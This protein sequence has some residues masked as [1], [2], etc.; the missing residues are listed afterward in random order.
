MDIHKAG[1]PKVH[2]HDL[3]H[4]HATILLAKEVNVKI[5]SERLKVIEI[6]KSH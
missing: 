3:R 1:V 4:T 6:S 5:I 2:F